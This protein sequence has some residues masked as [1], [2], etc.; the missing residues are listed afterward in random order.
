MRATLA[1]VLAAVVLAACRTTAPAPIVTKPQ[2]PLTPGPA[3]PEPRIA[4]VL[5]GGAARGFAHIGVIRV[6]EQERIPVDL[7]VGTSVGSLIGALYASDRDSF[8]LEWTAFQLQQDDLFDF[9]LVNAVLGM[10]YARGQKLEAF[11]KGKVKQ[12]NIE[13]LAVPFAAVATDLN[14][15]GRVVLDKGPVASAV[16]ASSAIPGIFEPV[17]HQGKLLVDGGVVDNIPIDVARE[18]GA[19]LVVAVDIS[20]D[21]GNTSIKNAIDVLLQATNI[22]FE[23]NVAA[24]RQGA[25]VLVQPKVG[26]VGMLDFSKKKECVQAG[27]DAA[28]AAMPRIRAAIEAWK[29]RKAEALRSRS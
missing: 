28:R 6:L 5:G 11:V 22:M 24:R 12:P 26:G 19:D 17:V 13:Q 15:G 29:A 25:D 14:W 4:L 21:V 2:E 8:A 3:V 20:Q 23:V 9:G 7:V 18:R 10:G 27:I 16:H 1:T